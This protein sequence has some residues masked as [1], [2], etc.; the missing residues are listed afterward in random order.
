MNI[1]ARNISKSY[2]RKGT[3]GEVQVLCST[4][5][6]LE[7]GKICLINGRSG[8]GKSTLLNILSGLLCASG[9]TVHYDGTDIYKLSDTELS[10]L[11]CRQTGYIPQVQSAVGTLTVR[12]NILLPSAVIG[13]GKDRFA[14]DGLL[15]RFGLTELADAR[16]G[17]LSGG[18]LRRLSIARAFVNSSGGELRRLSIVRALVNSPQAIFADEPTNDL[19]DENSRLVFEQLRKAADSGAAVVIVSHDRLAQEYA[20][21]VY[22]M[23]KGS[24]NRE[25]GRI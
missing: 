10:L 25:K 24:L 3:S 5:I 4:D 21:V 19:D 18:E 7:S 8:S 22:C 6:D 1:T 13:K 11:R 9:G 16:P 2:K 15:E 20:D 23:Q 14:A 17:S 12:E